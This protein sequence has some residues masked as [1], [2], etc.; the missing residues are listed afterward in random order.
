MRKGNTEMTIEKVCGRDDFYGEARRAVLVDK[1]TGVMYLQT[2]LSGNYGFAIS[3]IP[4]L[5]SE[6]KPKLI[7][8]HYGNEVDFT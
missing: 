4:L 6:G 8:V 1:D 7:N 2:T 5:D 3:V